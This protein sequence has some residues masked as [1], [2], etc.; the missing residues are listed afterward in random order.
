[1][2]NNKKTVTIVLFALI[3][4]I[5]LAIGYAT[6][7][8]INLTI[9]GSA[10]ASPD[11]SSFEVKFLNDLDGDDENNPRNIEYE[12]RLTTG[13]VVYTNNKP[14]STRPAVVDSDLT[15]HFNTQQLSAAGEKAIATYRVKNTSPNLSANLNV[16][17]SS[18]NPEYFQTTCKLG[19]VSSSESLVSG[20]VTTVTVEVTVLKTPI[21]DA[22]ASTISTVITATPS[23]S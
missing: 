1:M 19:N 5:V 6:I 8:A 12:E 11:S 16:I 21:E 4:V 14:Y 15:A 3:A 23:N 2:K 7:Q 18:T 9:T 22:Q 13:T 10:T 20:A 17:C